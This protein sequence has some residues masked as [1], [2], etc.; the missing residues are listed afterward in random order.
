MDLQLS[1]IVLSALTVGL[2]Q[3][4][5]Q[6]GVPSKFAPLLALVV[7]IG[8]SFLASIELH[9]SV[10]MSIFS[11]LIIALTSVG[12]YATGQHIAENTNA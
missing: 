4:G 3:L 8:L 11:G 2:V 1:S 5:K 6:V 9:T 10:V 12:M 7:G